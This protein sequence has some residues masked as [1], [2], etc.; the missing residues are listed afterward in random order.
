MQ[1]SFPSEMMI[2]QSKEPLGL[3]KE[4]FLTSSFSNP[5]SRDGISVDISSAKS[6]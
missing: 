3:S 4:S 5:E 1:P 2:S 6:L